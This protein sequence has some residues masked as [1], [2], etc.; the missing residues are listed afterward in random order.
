MLS[1]VDLYLVVREPACCALR[2]GTHTGL[3]PSVTVYRLLASFDNK[4]LTRYID[5]LSEESGSG[6]S[7]KPNP[8]LW[9]YEC[10]GIGKARGRKEEMDDLSFVTTD[11]YQYFA[12]KRAHPS[13]HSLIDY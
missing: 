4:Y 13:V 5:G 11:L 6:E 1:F 8:I 12:V 9:R 7:T 2:P 3:I 10:M